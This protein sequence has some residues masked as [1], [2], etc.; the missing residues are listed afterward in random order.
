MIE[1]Y[2]TV[3]SV[4]KRIIDNWW[5]F[6][7]DVIWLLV[8]CIM[9]PLTWHYTM[10]FEFRLKGAPFQRSFGVWNANVLKTIKKMSL[11]T[12][13]N[14]PEIICFAR[15]RSPVLLRGGGERCSFIF[16][17]RF[18][19]FSTLYYERT[20][21]ILFSHFLEI[22]DQ[23]LMFFRRVLDWPQR[24]LLGS[25]NRNWCREMVPKSEGARI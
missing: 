18:Y 16:F 3:K 6:D 7:N 20:V 14:M 24:L 25:V 22:F 19:W 17:D 2:I 1:K 12:K 21:E 8:V 5:L 4:I 9:C 15:V 23:K 10:N 11:S 13:K